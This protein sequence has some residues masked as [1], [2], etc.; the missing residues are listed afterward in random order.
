MQGS[1]IASPCIYV[2]PLFYQPCQ[3]HLGIQRIR[4]YELL[5]P[6]IESGDP[7]MSP[8]CVTHHVSIFFLFLFFFLIRSYVGKDEGGH[9]I[10]IWWLW[11]IANIV[12]D[13]WRQFNSCETAVHPPQALWYAK[14]TDNVQGP[15]R[16]ALCRSQQWIPKGILSFFFF[17]A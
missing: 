3:L 12:T 10:M 2:L 17:F 11:G 5:D 14:S 1:T 15:V 16:I 7:K 6:S 13:I 8:C 4:V 9:A